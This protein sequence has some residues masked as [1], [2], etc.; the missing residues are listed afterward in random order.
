MRLTCGAILVQKHVQLCTAVPYELVGTTVPASTYCG[1]VFTRPIL[2]G[3]L[4]KIN[5]TR[6]VK[7]R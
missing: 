3:Y 5:E 6:I 4:T 7:L 2:S 1:T